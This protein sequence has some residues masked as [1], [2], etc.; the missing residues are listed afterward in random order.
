MG[1]LGIL[2]ED[3]RLELIAGDIVVREPI[4]SNHAGTVNR[5]NR[6]WSSGVKEDA[7][8]RRDAGASPRPSGLESLPGRTPS[9]GLP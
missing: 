9:P 8:V 3:S 6:L 2:P 7:K 1:E 4:G 5:L